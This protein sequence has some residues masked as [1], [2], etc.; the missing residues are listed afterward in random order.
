MRKLPLIALVSA[1]ALPFA[2]PATVQAADTAA[3]KT[4]AADEPSGKNVKPSEP[5]A[6]PDTRSEKAKAEGAVPKA[7]AAD[8]PSGKNVKAAEPKKRADT[9]SEKAKSEGAIPKTGGDE[10]S[11]VPQPKAK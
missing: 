9:R 7:G 1:L 4:G 2:G 11:K 8:E 6:R 10:P 3:P 5:K